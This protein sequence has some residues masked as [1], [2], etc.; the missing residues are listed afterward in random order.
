MK[1][2]SD[3]VTNSSSYSSVVVRIQSKKLAELL[4]QYQELFNSDVQVLPDGILVEE[5]ETADGWDDA[6]QSLEQ[7]IDR[8]LE[9]LEW[10]IQVEEQDPLA[11]QMERDIKA[12]Q[13][14]LTDSVQKAVWDFQNNSY[15]EFVYEGMT[16]RKRFAYDKGQGGKGDYREEPYREDGYEDDGEF[17]EIFDGF[18]ENEEE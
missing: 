15:G 8:L 6:P 10:E 16:G 5:Y 1:I 14:E 4:V 17:D 12:N 13:Q 3:F 9:G 7:L 18:D 2:I 11:R